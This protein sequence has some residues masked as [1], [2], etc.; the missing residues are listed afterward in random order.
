MPATAAETVSFAPPD[1]VLVKV[2]PP[3]FTVSAVVLIVS[4]EVPL[5]S[6]IAVTF[7]PMPPLI[8]VPPEPVPALVIVPALL[9]AA[10]EKAVA[11]LEGFV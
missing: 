3:L 1:D 4:A 11:P 9:I 2:V 6:V 10:V 7:D 8:V 5:F